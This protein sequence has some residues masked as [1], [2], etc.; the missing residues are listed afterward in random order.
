VGGL[1]IGR[2]SHRAARQGAGAKWGKK[3][4]AAGEGGR[5][6]RISRAGDQCRGA[7]WVGAAQGTRARRSSA[8]ALGCGSGIGIPI[9]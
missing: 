4:A 1:R 3:I 5:S 2:S 8:A 9:S 6:A 7:R